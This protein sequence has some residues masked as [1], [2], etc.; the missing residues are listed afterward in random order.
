MSNGQIPVG[1]ESMVMGDQRVA[2]SIILSL[3]PRLQNFD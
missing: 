2:D 3:S 1:D